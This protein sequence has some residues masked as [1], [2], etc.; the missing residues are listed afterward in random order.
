MSNLHVRKSDLAVG[1]MSYSR[2]LGGR[3]AVAELHKLTELLENVRLGLAVDCQGVEMG[4]SDVI[5]LLLRLSKKAKGDNKH[6]VL[7][8]VP[9]QLQQS[10]KVTGLKSIV[11]ICDDAPEAKGLI[12]KNSGVADPSAPTTPTETGKG[13]LVAAIA[14]LVVALCISIGTFV[15]FLR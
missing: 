1:T 10:I 12:Y 8:N 3:H 5:N 2:Q 6:V 14:F 11:T 9:D 13:K 7:F 4:T 15:V